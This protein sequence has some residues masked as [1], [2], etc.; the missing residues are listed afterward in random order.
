MAARKGMPRLI[1]KICLWCQG[2]SLKLVQECSQGDCPLHSHRLQDDGDDRVLGRCLG[3]YCLRCAGS[4]ESVVE[5]TAHQRFGVHGPCPAYPYRIPENVSETLQVRCTQR[6]LP[7]LDMAVARRAS[8]SG[9]GREPFPCLPVR[10]QSQ[11][12]SYGFLT[13]ECTP[14]ALDI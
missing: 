12:G 8:G 5:C 11:L 3:D 7:G 14:E 4:P 6:V 10:P 2:D 1:R 9:P 13:V